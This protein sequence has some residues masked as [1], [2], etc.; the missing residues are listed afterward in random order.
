MPTV[1]NVT[2]LN[3]LPSQTFVPVCAIGASAGGVGA[4]Q[5]L[6]RHVPADLGLAYVVILHLSPDQPSA[7]SEVLSV[8]TKMPVHQIEDGP[9]LKPNCIYVI[10]PD[11][12]LVID[13]DSVTARPFSEPR[14]RRAPIDMFFRSI[15]AA[16]GDGIAIVLSGAGADGSVGVRAVKEAGGVVMVQ[17]PAEAGFSSMPQN[18]IATGCADFIAPIARLTE[19]LSEVAHSKEAVRSL[20]MDGA[21]ND[22]R[23]I[24]SFLRKRTG[25]DFSS[26]KRATI[27]RRVIRRMQ[28]CRVET[29]ADYAAY[30]ATTAEEAKELFSD[31]LISVTMFFR[32]P[33]AFEALARHTVKPLF[34]TLEDE[35]NG[36]IRVWVVGCATG[37]EAYSIAMLLHEEAARRKVSYPIQIFATDLDEGALAT[38]REGRYPRSIEADVSEERLARFFIDEGT[39]YRIRKEIRDSVLFAAHSVLKEPPFLR[40]DLITCRNLLIYLERV[41]QQQV[42]SIFHYGL[43]P[44]RFLFLGSAETADM[45][46]DL[47]APLDREARIY[48]ALPQAHHTLPLLPQFT[49][50]DRSVVLASP[51]PS[52]R[53]AHGDVRE[54][55]SAALHVA[56]LERSAPASA[57]VDAG[58]NILHLSPGA[59]RF[60]LHS[61]GPISNLL[62]AIVRPELRLDLK[63]ALTR[64]LEQKLPTLTHPVTVTF[65]QDRRQVAM[66]VALVPSEA[67][68]GARALVFFLDGGPVRE[69]EEAAS[70]SDLQPDEVRR[71]HIELK[72]AQEA[73]VVSRSGHEVSIQDLRAANEELQSINEEYRSTAE[74]LETSKEELQSINEEL[75]TVNAALKSKLESISVAHSDLQNLT[76]ATEI[77]TLFLDPELRIK[78]FTPPIAE[79]FNVTTTDIGRAITDFTHCLAYDAIAEDVRTVLQKLVPIEREIR[80]KNGRRYVMRLRPYRTVE[81]RIDG[82]V[83]TFIDV[84][85]R[86]E[87]EAALGR[88]EQQLRALV[89]ASSQVLY[90]MS[91]DWEEMRELAGGGFLPNTEAPGGSW[92]DRYIPEDEQARVRAAIQEA[93]RKGEV[94]DLEHR[95]RRVDGTVGWTHSRAIPLFDSA[96]N[97][98][99]WF[100]SA[101]DVTQRRQAEEAQRQSEER[102]RALIEGIPQLVWQATDDGRWVWASSQWYTFTGLTEEQSRDYGWLEAVHPDDR[103]MARAAWLEAKT[104]GVLSIEFRIWHVQENRYRWFTQRGTPVRDGTGRVIEWLGTS[105]DIDDLRQLQDE[106][107]VMVAELQHRT[108]NLLGVVR[109]IA[110]QTLAQTGPTEAFREQFSERLAALSR[111]Q[112]LLSRSEQEPITIRMLIETELD[113]LGASAMQDR[114]VLEGPVVRLRKAAVQTFA[115][116]LHELATNAHK[117]GALTTEHGQL[118]VTWRTYEAA[119][120]GRRLA[121]EWL[122]EGISRPR[123]EQSPVSKQLGYGRELIERAL[124]Y[125]LKARTSYELGETALRCSID[126]PLAKPA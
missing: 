78:M 37:E 121:L 22:L 83:V 58:Q 56:A 5:S 94:F 100:G 90:R 48:S 107:K 111:V 11:R 3:P 106:Q 120:E 118:R 43:K 92:L 80:S 102:L 76:A 119:G 36:E 98:T 32:D 73:L 57:L 124:P 70:T 30:L 28:V 74:E 59:G 35:D 88:S 87:A 4:L 91:P 52:A 14:G 63:L 68:M 34:D 38:A 125:I 122:E 13:G 105:T 50:P 27:M 104:T 20:D 114:I 23:R 62:P 18:A 86:L 84:S 33:H 10:P 16:R 93:K 108:R 17:E 113:A 29:L 7:L 40:L 126:L 96:G 67:H 15:A 45:A 64:A 31:L 61:A 1:P 116:A 81:D 24:I 101:S 103:E 2:E 71:L 89:Q 77:G 53:L 75:H 85:E 41:L 21:A 123:E 69:D 54:G 51:L 6:F 66:H 82:T 72:A 97:I 99:E 109:S 42:C 49:T 117:Y 19:R 95:V 112:G 39:H 55:L 8:C 60:I 65:D 12:E 79:L 110:Q 25:H 44:G 26:Y 115:L 47:F 46:A 9:T